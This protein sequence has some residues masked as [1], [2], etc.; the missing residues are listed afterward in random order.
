LGA[1]VNDAWHL[2]ER[3]QQPKENPMHKLFAFIS[4]ALLAI[5]T[6]TLAFAQTFGVPTLTISAY[7]YANITT[8]ATT[9][10][11]SSSGIL[12]S[13]C[14]NKPTATEVITLYDNTAAS[15][16]IIGTITIPASPMP[17]C[18]TYDI[19]FITGLTI[20]TATATS[21]ITISYF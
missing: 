8:D 6:T 20:V 1:L 15:G 18:L 9:T 17:I 10:V 7:K 12:H 5:F 19:N 16:T 11:K 2:L 21:D 13:I 14:F 3:T 4:A